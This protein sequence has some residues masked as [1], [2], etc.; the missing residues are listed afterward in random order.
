MYK[1]LVFL[2]RFFKQLH[3]TQI[4]QVNRDNF[5]GIVCALVIVSR[6]NKEEGGTHYLHEVLIIYQA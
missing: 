5:D 3:V 1:S 6:A 2:P 4:Y